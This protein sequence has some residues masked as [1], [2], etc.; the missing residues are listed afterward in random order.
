MA[1][2]GIRAEL[3]A[4]ADRLAAQGSRL[5]QELQHLSD[6]RGAWEKSSKEVESAKA[7]PQVLQEI[8]RILTAIGAAQAQVNARLA[9]LL[10]LQYQVGLEIRRCD[11]ILAQI[12]QAKS[13]LVDH[14]A[15]QDAPPMWSPAVWAG[16]RNQIIPG[17]QAAAGRLQS[18]LRIVVQNQ[19]KGVALQALLFVVL[20]SLLILARSRAHDWIL[21]DTG[22]ASAARM[23]ER[24]V[25]AALV[26]TLLATPWIYPS[27]ALAVFRIA[28]LVGVIPALRL[29]APLFSGAQTRRL[30]GFGAVIVVEALRSRCS[31]G[32]CCS[33]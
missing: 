33:A 12:A 29:L 8:N 21:P 22:I 23:L 25:S 16:A 24:P 4:W 10:V 5:Q 19:L 32:A 2:T 30:Y 20:L 1:W 13:D 15:T 7:P 3:T 26:L 31:A 11:Q 27:Y 18:E 6:L 17:L 9:S 28:K 14:L